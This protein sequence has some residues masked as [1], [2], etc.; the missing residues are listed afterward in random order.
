MA[1]VTVNPGPR[2]EK[3][4]LK[5]ILR[6]YLKHAEDIAWAKVIKKYG[7]AREEYKIRLNKLS[8]LRADPFF[9]FEWNTTGATSP[10]VDKGT[11]I[12][13]MDAS[14]VT[15]SEVEAKMYNDM[16][17]WAPQALNRFAKRLDTHAT[18]EEYWGG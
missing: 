8:F 14:Y 7:K 4:E 17:R 15:F 12:I 3:G 5:R 13:Y 1:K 18:T 9:E 11:Q 16:P 2:P 10:R 6:V